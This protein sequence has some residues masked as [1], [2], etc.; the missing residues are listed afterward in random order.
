MGKTRTNVCIVV[1]RNRPTS[2]PKTYVGDLRPGNG[3]AVIVRSFPAAI[4]FSHGVDFDHG[5]SGWV[6]V[7]VDEPE[8][9]RRSKHACAR[10]RDG[11]HTCTCSLARTR[12]TSRAVG[13][14]RVGEMERLGACSRAGTLSAEQ[15]RGECGWVTRKEWA[16]ACMQK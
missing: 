4:S 13:W 15:R 10:R 3:A 1:E 6:P 8:G 2:A 7:E 16:R 5:G 14:A 11:L 9:G 12:A